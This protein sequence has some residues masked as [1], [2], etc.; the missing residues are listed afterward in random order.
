LKRYRETRARLQAYL[1]MG[2][3]EAMES[4]E[5]FSAYFSYRMQSFSN[6]EFSRTLNSGF[7]SMRDPQAVN[8]KKSVAMIVDMY[9]R[10]AG[11]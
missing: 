3:A 4:H 7:N 6:P 2:L 9:L 11:R 10:G 1:K 8:I 5:L